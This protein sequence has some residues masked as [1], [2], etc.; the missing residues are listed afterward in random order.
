MN[1]NPSPP[2]LAD[3]IKELTGA[4]PFQ[5]SRTRPVIESRSLLCYLMR[6]KLN[7]RWTKIAE[8]LTENG[9]SCTHAT[10]INS[11]NSYYMHKTA[12]KELQLVESIFTFKKDLAI[13]EINKVDYLQDRCEKLQ[14][15]LELPLVKLVTRI[16]KNREQEALGFV[17]NIVKSF[18]WKYDDKEII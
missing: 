4:N 15:Q 2:E 3:K 10:V 6:N 5:N 13:D 18:V 1:F 11:V 17:R 12:N 14:A 7:M 9:K 16:P 8:F